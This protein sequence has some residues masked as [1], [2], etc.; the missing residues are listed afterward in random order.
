MV[1]MCFVFL[2][3]IWLLL[4]VLRYLNFLILS[5]WS[6]W[7]GF[8]LEN[9]FVRVVMVLELI[10]VYKVSFW[11]VWLCCN[12]RVRLFVICWVMLINFSCSFWM[13]VFIRNIFVMC[14]MYLVFNGCWNW[15]LLYMLSLCR[16]WFDCNVV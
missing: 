15:L 9:G 10:W 7:F 8:C 3:L 11:R 13:F 2:F 14:F 16:V 4:C 1:V 12:V 6:V 5:F